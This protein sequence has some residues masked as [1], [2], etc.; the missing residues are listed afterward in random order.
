MQSQPKISVIIPVYNAEKYIA[1]CLTSVLGQTLTAIEVIVVNDGST[2]NSYK[3]IQQFAQT[4][5]RIKIFTIS[6]SGPSSARNMGLSKARGD[7]IGF[8]DA[9]DFIEKTMFESLFDAASKSQSELTICN[10]KI[11]DENKNNTIRLNL[12]N[13]V[14]IIDKGV[15]SLIEDLL[16]FKYDYANWNK[17]YVNQ[18][19]QNKHIKFDTKITL[20]EDLLFNLMYALHVRKLAVINE[21]LYSYNINISSLYSTKAFKQFFE[22][23]KL[24]IIFDSYCTSYNHKVELNLFRKKIAPILFYALNN[25]FQHIQS[26]KNRKE[27]NIELIKNLKQLHGSYNYF[28]NLDNKKY[29]IPQKVL[30]YALKLELSYLVIKLLISKNIFVQRHAFN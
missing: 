3:I 8:V 15:N 17:L 27:L 16:D 14:Q 4:D 11:I 5:N 19:I 23:T 1:R 12:K 29:N 24:S 22:F 28:K 9:D 18:I 2:D 30:I 13:E 25:S 6:N 20:G 21:P 7:Y 26:Q 10:I